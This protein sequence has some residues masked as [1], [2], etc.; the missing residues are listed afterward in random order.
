MNMS[1]SLL[2]VVLLATAA[3]VGC[4]SN[5]PPVKANAFV[6]PSD[7]HGNFYADASKEQATTRT[8]NRSNSH[9]GEF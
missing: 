3:M 6:S 9:G 1:K 2:M 5:L 8:H 7:S 4:A